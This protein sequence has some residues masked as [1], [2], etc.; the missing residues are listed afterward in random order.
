MSNNVGI[1]TGAVKWG[2]GDWD[3]LLAYLPDYAFEEYEHLLQI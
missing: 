3:E 1:K 2:L